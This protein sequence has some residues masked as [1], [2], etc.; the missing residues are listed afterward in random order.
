MNIAD[1]D[2]QF[3]MLVESLRWITAI[4]SRYTEQHSRTC[5]G[6]LAI[7]IGKHLTSLL[8]TEPLM[9]AGGLVLMYYRV[10]I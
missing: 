9:A 10:G 3:L 5:R 6:Q 7:T 1:A 4:M 2:E 8:R